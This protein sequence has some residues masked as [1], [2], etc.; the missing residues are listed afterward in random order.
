MIRVLIADDEIHFRNYMLTA[1]DW[2]ALGFQLCCVAQNGEEA[3]CTIR[4]FPPDIAFLDINMPLIDGISLAEKVRAQNPQLMLVFV[5]GYS[6]FS[7]TKKAIQLQVEDYLLKPFSPEELT[8]LLLR[9][10]QKYMQTHFPD[11]A[12]RRQKEAPPLHS[13]IRTSRS[14]EIVRR[15]QEYIRC[16]YM[17]EAF[18]VE[19][20]AAYMILDASYLRKLFNKYM[21]CTISD[22]LTATRMEE[23]RRLLDQGETNITQ[24]SSQSGYK[25]SGYFSK[26]FKKYYG[27]T[28][29]AYLTDGLEGGPGSPAISNVRQARNAAGQQ[30]I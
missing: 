30:D 16:H 10:R 24:V 22:F 14:L 4:D 20:I 13:S 27:V 23:A 5:T 15:V 8:E 7:H 6:D 12:I 18:S 1:V 26:V 25:D 3:L 21:N 17:E 11:R 19:Q 29:R 9:L 28:P 2:N